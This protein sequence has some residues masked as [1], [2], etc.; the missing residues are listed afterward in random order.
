MAVMSDAARTGEPAAS[1][2]H[3]GSFIAGMGIGQIISWGSLYYSFPLI[4]GPMGRDL[5]LSRPEIYGAATVGLVVG[6][7]TTYPIG[8]AIDRGHGRGIMACGSVL[9]GLLLVA[10]SHITSLWALYCLF[11]GI[12]LAQAMTLYEPAMAIVARRYGAEAR[13]GITALTLWGGFASTV[14]VPVVQWL[15]D[16]GGWRAAL[17]ALGLLNL[18]LCVVLHLAVINSQADALEPSLSSMPGGRVPPVSQHTVRWALRQSAF[19]GLLVSF[20]VYYGTFSGISFHLYP[21]LLE[22]GCDVA[23]VVGVIAL[24]GPAQVAG[25]LAMWVLGR[26]QSAGTIG[27]ATVLAFPLS[28]LLLML[29]PSSF[30]SLA[31]FAVIYGAANGVMTI[32]RGLAVPELLTREAYGA[33]NGVLAA[34]GIVA[35][36]LA[37]AVTALLW[38]AAHS[39]DTVLIAAVMGSVLVVLSFWFAVAVTRGRGAVLNNP[40]KATS[41]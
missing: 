32:V 28:L 36:A 34:P 22:R 31:V 9:G 24:I 3:R 15:L 23:T 13:T 19:W 16:Y 41:Q 40:G 25:R 10:W 2:C 7:L 17:W 8:V 33:I 29:L 18:G 4:A 11:V 37:P 14:F 38:A 27:L 35:R 30:A 20:T 12:G 5:A 1:R 6:S 21:L 39:Y 26:N